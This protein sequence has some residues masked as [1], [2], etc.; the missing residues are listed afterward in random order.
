MIPNSLCPFTN[1]T[2][3]NVL[4]I[5]LCLWAKY[6]PSKIKT[7]KRNVKCERQLY[8]VSM[9]MSIIPFMR[10]TIS[11]RH[12]ENYA[13]TP[14][15]TFYMNI[16]TYTKKA[17]DRVQFECNHINSFSIFFYNINPTV[18]RYVGIIDSGRNTE[19]PSFSPK[20]GKLIWK[21]SEK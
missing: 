19:I 7:F 14:I 6:I 5:Y 16:V 8:I 3:I 20:E 1:G 13:K 9:I 21:W 4:A 15:F 11:A 17:G 18:I 12:V 10:Y 2:S